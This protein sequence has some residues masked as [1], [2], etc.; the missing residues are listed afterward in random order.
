MD[1]K[2]VVVINGKGGV[3]KDTVI[4]AVK[5][6]YVVYTAS[7]I[8]PIKAVAAMLG[9]DM[10][11]DLRSRKFLS[12]L[13]QLS[14]EYNDYPTKYLVDQFHD[15]EESDAQVMFIHIREPEEIDKF[16]AAVDCVTLLVRN[17]RVRGNFGNRSDDDVENYQY[18][19]VYDNV[20][21]LD[22]MK[23]DFLSFFETKILKRLEG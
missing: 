16:K 12:D 10:Q 1:S 5:D 4:N 21:Q 17:P 13:K 19:F 18:D 2:T 7:A 8:D 20:L 11:K 14:I 22:T 6:Q 15:F 3:G 23:A 9:W